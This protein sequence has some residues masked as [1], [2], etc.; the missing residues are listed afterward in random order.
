MLGVIYFYSDAGVALE[1]AKAIYWTQKT[2]SQSLDGVPQNYSEVIEWFRKAQHQFGMM[3]LLGDGIARDFLCGQYAR[4]L[5]ERPR[6]FST[7][8]AL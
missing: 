1:Y 4:P 7:L 3:Y 2:A 8:N 5:P 6:R